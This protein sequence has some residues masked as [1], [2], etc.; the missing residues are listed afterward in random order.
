MLLCTLIYFD[1]I[2]Q[3]YV[4]LYIVNCFEWQHDSVL[5]SLALLQFLQD[6]TYFEVTS[7]GCERA[8]HFR[9]WTFLVQ[10]FFH[11]VSWYGL[12]FTMQMTSYWKFEANL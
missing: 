12:F 7:M 4:G 8:E 11:H 9:F 5:L 6:L 2:M 10:V 1:I 3:W